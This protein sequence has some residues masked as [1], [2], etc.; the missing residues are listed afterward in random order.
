MG[1]LVGYY[2]L[3][4]RWVVVGWGW[5]V[6][7]C[8]VGLVLDFFLLLTYLLNVLTYVLNVWTMC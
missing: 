1:V 5:K 3:G 7:W 6:T 2:D 4:R 8:V